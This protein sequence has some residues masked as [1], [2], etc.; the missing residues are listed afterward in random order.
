MTRDLVLIS[1]SLLTW[2]LGEG[3]FFSF[4]PLYLQHLGAKPIA[5]GGILGGFSFAAMLVHLPAGYLSDKLGRRPLLIS[6]W[7]IG[8]IAVIFMVSSNTLL[9]FV[10][11]LFIYGSTGFVVAPLNSYLV[12]SS[13]RLSTAR[14]FTL[15]SAAY[16]FGAMFGPLIGGQIGE[17]FS[18]RHIFV[19]TAILTGFSTFL[20]Y[21]IRPQPVSPASKTTSIVRSIFNREYVLFVLV[22]FVMVFATYLP[23]PLT[24]NFLQNQHK[25]AVSTIGTLF[26]LNGLGIVVFNLLVGSLSAFRGW[27]ISQFFVIL[28]AVILWKCN[29]LPLFGLAFFI[30]GGFR[31]ARTMGTAQ[32]RAFV[33]PDNMGVAFGFAETINA[34][35]LILASIFAGYLYAIRPDSMYWVSVILTLIAIALAFGF[36]RILKSTRTK[37]QSA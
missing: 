5:I 37:V 12:H 24:P 19:F 36:H 23:Q 33:E 17:H 18:L 27:M 11:S 4:I 26:F 28:F 20:I 13:S 2:G 25:L 35:A 34:L 3:A 14:L 30:L 7:A 16:N 10:I 6:A 9:P 29:S 1:F 22:L 15:V 32:L 21:F 8:F 31:A